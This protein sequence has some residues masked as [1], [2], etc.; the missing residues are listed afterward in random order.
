MQWRHQV[1]SDLPTYS[2]PNNQIA[3]NIPA[4]PVQACRSPCREVARTVRGYREQPEYTQKKHSRVVIHCRGG[5]PTECARDR[6]P[7]L[8]RNI[9]GATGR[10]GTLCAAQPHAISTTFGRVANIMGRPSKDDIGKME[11]C[12]RS[13]GAIADMNHIYIMIITGQ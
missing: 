13:L 2:T 5:R 8:Q 1:V 6:L 7:S 12:M 10:A 4:S 3:A 9:C 11:S